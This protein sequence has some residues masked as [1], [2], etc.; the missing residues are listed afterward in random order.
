MD[1]ETSRTETSR[2]DLLLQGGG[3]P[4]FNVCYEC[5]FPSRSHCVLAMLKG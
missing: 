2:I 1:T 5:L 3:L 4:R